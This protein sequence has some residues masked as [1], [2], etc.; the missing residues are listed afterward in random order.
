MKP[1][2]H[3][4]KVGEVHIAYQVFGQGDEDLVLV[5]GYMSNVDL[6][7]DEPVVVRF[8]EDLGRFCRVILFEKR[9]TGLSDPINGAATLEDRVDDVRGVMDA[10][11]SKRATI[12]GYSEGAAMSLLFAA[13]HPERTQALVLVGGYACRG[14][15]PDYPIG[16][17]AESQKAFLEIVE[18][19]W[20][21]FDIDRRIP[22]LA[23][24]TRFRA[25]WGKFMR[26]GCSVAAALA[27]SRMNFE[28][29]VRPVLPTIRVPTLVLHSVRDAVIP[30]AHGRYMAE[31]IPGAQMVELDADDHV[32]FA[33]TADAVVARIET[34]L[35]GGHAPPMDDRVLGTILF[36][37]IVG[38]T[39]LAG[40][41][42]DR[43]WTDLLAAHDAAVR[44]ALAVHR[45]REVNTTGDGVIAMFDGPA[46]AIRCGAAIRDAVA[47]L[48]LQAR[49]GIHTGECVLR[50]EDIAG[51]AVHIAAR[52]GALAGEGE[53]LV[54][55]TVRD[56]VVGSGI[57]FDRLGAHELR[58]VEGEWTVCRVASTS[59]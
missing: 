46:R 45:G 37:D 15:K 21:P 44:G 53:I 17:D 49:V 55:Q 57:G 47:A 43:A 39:D 3:Y 7:W 20:G 42:G 38:S 54:S 59:R 2:T 14:A 1:E 27:I 28:I 41:L 35:T 25:W 36:T 33:Q 40:R 31:R 19:R 9:G 23:G 29:D 6:W 22:S 48:G 32:P 8:F 26:G 13:T 11:E 10:V 30:V 50:G 16:V 12:F 34:L 5:P 24:D 18:T 52:I 4:T 51:I 58:G 56:L